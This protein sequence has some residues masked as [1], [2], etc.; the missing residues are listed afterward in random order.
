MCWN[1]SGPV[2]NYHQRGLGLGLP[3]HTFL[4]SWHHH[5]YG[6]PFVIKWPVGQGRGL[7]GRVRRVRGRGSMVDASVSSWLLP[8]NSEAGHFQ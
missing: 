1:V 5:S 8:I 6:P 4:M 3:I 2:C 7:G